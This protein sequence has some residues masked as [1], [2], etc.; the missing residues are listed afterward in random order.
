MYN[1]IY[2]LIDLFFYLG[3]AILLSIAFQSAQGRFNFHNKYARSLIFIVQYVVVQMYL[4]NS[5]IIKTIVFGDDGV[6]VNSRFSMAFVIL[7]FVVT[8]TFARVLL[9]ENRLKI[10]Y[11]ALS[12]YAIIELVKSALY[13][14]FVKLL[15]IVINCITHFYLE[16]QMYDA[17]TFQALAQSAEIIWNIMYCVVELIVSWLIIR[18]L[19]S[20]LNMKDTY[21]KWE[22]VFLLFPNLIG[23]VICMIVRSIMCSVNGTDMFLL[24]ETRPEMN[25]LLPCISVLCIFSII[26]AAMMLRNLKDESN[27]RI[28]LVVYKNKVEEMEKHIE[29]IESLYDGIRGMRHDMKNYIAD[30]DA[31]MKQDEDDPL[32]KVELRKYLESLQLSVDNLD[33]KYHTGNPVTDVVMQRYVQ[34]AE[35]NCIE[36]NADFLFPSDMGVNAFDLSIIMNNALENAIEACINQKEGRKS[37]TLSSYRRENMFFIIIRNSFDGVLSKKEGKI[38]STKLDA[39]N[40]GYGLQNIEACVEKYYGRAETTVADGYFELAVMLQKQE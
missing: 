10:C 6:N 37:I 24:L 7:S 17:A 29:D 38:K 25:F 23:L 40:H 31:L 39:G 11:Y 16:K 4:H 8:Y 14:V 13:A 1:I 36:F 30:M 32:I 27:K 19:K 2:F 3:Q 34:L 5:K 33:M 9:K 18:K 15:N 21:Q 28:E 22:Q 35:K 12:F 26:F 20:Y